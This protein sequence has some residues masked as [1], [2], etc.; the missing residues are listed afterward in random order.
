MFSGCCSG[1]KISKTCKPCIISTHLTYGS[2]IKNLLIHNTSSAVTNETM[3]NITA[4]Y[5][6]KHIDNG[7]QRLYFATYD[8]KLKAI[9]NLF[10]YNSILILFNMICN[11]CFSELDY[12]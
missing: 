4:E 1:L 11:P 6:I 5:C 7:I 10:Y 8:L 3:V 12:I 2:A 9:D